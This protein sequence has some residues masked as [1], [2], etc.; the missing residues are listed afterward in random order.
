MTKTKGLL[1]MDVDSTLIQ[2]DLSC[3]EI[4]GSGAEIAD[5]TSRAMNGE[6]D[7]A[8]ALAAR[9]GL[10]KGLPE[11]V[12]SEVRKQIHFTEGAR[13]LVAALQANGWKV[14]VVSGGFHE[15][16]DDLARELG[17][18]YVRANHLEIVDG[19]LTGKT[20]G[21]I[22]TKEVKLASLK[23]WAAELGLEL[24]QTVAMGDGANDL[25]MILASGIGIAFHAKPVVR[26]QAPYQ[27]N[28]PNLA[29]ALDIIKEVKGDL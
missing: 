16:V 9:V 25:P 1:I 29:L 17:L 28:T 20:T 14:G 23:K 21:D 6:L 2:E 22:V 19:Q 3:G 10:L 13:D 26:E 11:T 5:I 8:E 27:I 7:F 4:A 15:T 24:S 18:D 12:F